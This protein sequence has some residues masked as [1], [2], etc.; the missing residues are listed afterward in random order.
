MRYFFIRSQLV[1]VSIL[2]LLTMG[3]TLAI[4]IRHN[5]RWDLTREKIYSLSEPTKKLLE[6]LNDGVLEV[7]AFYP[8]DDPAQKDFEIFLKECQ[9]VHRGFKYN[10]YDP[11]RVPT[12]ANQF[13]VTDLYTVIIRYKDRQERIVRPTEES[14]TNAMLKLANPRS[15]QLCFVTG[16]GEASLEREDRSGYYLFRQALEDTNYTVH[17][18]ILER[19]KIPSLCQVIAIPGPHRNLESEAID[20][21]REAFQQGRGIFFLVDP[22]DPGT[23]DVFVDFAR[24]YGVALGRDVIVDK[25]SRMVGGDF[26]VPLVSQY[27]ANHPITDGFEIATFFPVARSVNPSTEGAGDLEVLPL[28]FSGSG[29]WAESGLESLEKGEAAFDADRDLSGPIPIAVSV[30]KA[31]RGD[32]QPGGR[33]VVVGDSDFLTNAYIDLSGN[34]DLALNMIQ[35]LARDDRFISVRPRQPV[36]E[37]LL[38]SPEQRFVLLAVL[39]GGFPLFF[40]ITGG[41]HMILRNRAS[42]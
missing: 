27:V 18:I 37:P 16:H 19:D 8:Y 28:A 12:L 24:Y 22:M 42:R 7:Y 23:G 14:F 41:L 1:I 32:G 5:K 2:L 36:F 21:L 39:L 17:E 10:F 9:L 25:M 20:L 30:E 40:L 6:A 35:W 33:M 29:S 31:D 15:L 11:D 4:V 38:L 34:R 26:L 3:M 13:H